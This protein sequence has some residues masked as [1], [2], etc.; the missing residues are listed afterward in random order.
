MSSKY[1]PLKAVAA[2]TGLTH[3]QVRLLVEQGPPVGPVAYRIGRRLIKV[4]RSD[5]DEWL[6][7]S[8]IRPAA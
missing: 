1:L 7:A 4:L 3:S 2:E 8:V 5:L 6:A